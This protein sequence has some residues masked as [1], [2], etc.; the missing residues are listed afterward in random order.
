MRPARGSPKPMHQPPAHTH[1]DVWAALVEGLDDIVFVVDGHDASVT[2]MNASARRAFGATSSVAAGVVVSDLYVN[3]GR[4]LPLEIIGAVRAR[5]RWRGEIEMIGAN[6]ERLLTYQTVTGEPDR[7]GHIEQ[8]V[9]VARDITAQRAMNA[10]LAHRATHDSLTGLPNRM[11]LLNHLD[12]S[13]ARARRH[14]RSIALLFCD[15]DRLKSINDLYGHDAGDRLLCQAAERIRTAMRPS[16]MVAR[17]GGDE[18]VVLCDDLEAEGDVRVIARRLLDGLN[19]EPFDIGGPPVNL[20]ASIGIALSHGEDHPEGLLREADAAMYRAKSQ[21]RNGYEI[22]DEA[23]RGR[24]VHEQRTADELVEGL[25]LNE[26]EVHFQPA[27]DLL[28]LELVA[29]EALVRWRHPTRGLLSPDQFISVAEQSGQAMSLSIQVLDQVCDRVLQ[30]HELLGDAAPKAHINLSPTLLGTDE[31]VDRHLDLLHTRRVDPTWI[32]IEVVESA[33][34]DESSGAIDRLRRLRDAGVSVAIDDFGT[35]YAS[36][37]YLHRL[38]A[39]TI[40]IDKS[41]VAGLDDEGSWDEAII[42]ALMELARRLDIHVIAEGIETEGQAQ[43]LRILGC[44]YGQGF[45]FARAAPAEELLP[46][47]IASARNFQSTTTTPAAPTQLA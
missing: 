5:G 16:D 35:G 8:F 25:R 9:I 34:I 47:M 42:A 30:W 24:M 10:E 27:V 4:R 32:C 11:M 29:V 17:I 19:S 20:T 43:M 13:L 23:M 21:G 40:K 46:L 39:D 22:F 2:Y 37:E 41:F 26:L 6:G 14:D 28:T 15:F 45:L 36:L 33:V 7:D 18:F 38:P 3:K 44:R 12:I 31:A 1:P